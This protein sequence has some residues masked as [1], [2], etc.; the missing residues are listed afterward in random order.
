MYEIS[1][2]W[3]KRKDDFD[4]DKTPWWA[5]P[6]ASCP[7]FTPK[8]VFDITREGFKHWADKSGVY[9]LERPDAPPPAPFIKGI[10]RLFPKPIMNGEIVPTMR[11]RYVDAWDR[12]GEFHGVEQWL[13]RALGLP[14]WGQ[15]ADFERIGYPLAR[16]M[17]AV[18]YLRNDDFVVKTSLYFP[19]DGYEESPDGFSA[20]E[21]VDKI[22]EY[23]PPYLLKRAVTEGR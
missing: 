4:I 19:G 23:M 6:C 14:T 17:D 16:M 13:R 22:E 3:W 21:T 1:I 2:T 7:K 8:E 11:L 5:K 20:E 9:A 10:D 15:A 12:G 18:V